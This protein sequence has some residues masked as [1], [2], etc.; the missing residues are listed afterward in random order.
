MCRNAEREKIGML[1][2]R[3]W[4]EILNIFVRSKMADNEWVWGSKQ[5]PCTQSRKTGK[6]TQACRFSLHSW[7][8]RKLSPL[9]MLSPWNVLL[10]INGPLKSFGFNGLN[11]NGSNLSNLTM[12]AF[13]GLKQFNDTR[14]LPY[15]P[16]PPHKRFDIEISHSTS[17]NRHHKLDITHLTSHTRHHTL[18]ITHWISHT[19][20][21]TLDITHSTS[22]T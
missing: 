4:W 7:A 10:S 8:Q 15:P 2:S 1:V 21:H 12:N 11:I 3:S 20:H 14:P 9:S 18:D 16:P 19:R 5:S 22:H 6:V 17:E 13:N